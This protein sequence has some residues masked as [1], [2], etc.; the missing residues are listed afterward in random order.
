MADSNY[1]F[2]AFYKYCEKCK[3]DMANN[4]SSVMEKPKRTIEE[5]KKPQPAGNRMRFLDR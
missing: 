2:V 5:P 4:L 1:Q 3:K